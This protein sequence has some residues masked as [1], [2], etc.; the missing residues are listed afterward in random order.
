LARP[1]GRRWPGADAVTKLGLVGQ[2][3]TRAIGAL[4][5]RLSLVQAGDEMAMLRVRGMAGDLTDLG[6]GALLLE[7]AAWEAAGVG[8]RLVAANRTPQEQQSAR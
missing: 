3:A 1:S 4:G 5:Y 6:Q 7:E 8:Y 2:G